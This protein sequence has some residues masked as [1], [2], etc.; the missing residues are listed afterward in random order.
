MQLTG[1]ERPGKCE[2][3]ILGSSEILHWGNTNC[4]CSSRD[5]ESELTAWQKLEEEFLKRTNNWE[6]NFSRGLPTIP[7]RTKTNKVDRIKLSKDWQG[8]HDVLPQMGILDTTS[9]HGGKPVRHLN[10]SL[11]WPILIKPLKARHEL[12]IRDRFSVPPE[13]FFQDLIN[14]IHNT[15][16]PDSP[17]RN[18]LY[19]WK[20]QIYPN[21]EQ[22]DY[23]MVSP[24]ILHYAHIAQKAT[25]IIMNYR[26]RMIL[27]TF[28]RLISTRKIGTR[29]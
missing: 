27:S 20:L 13:K 4:V 1:C 6:P 17:G 28:M 14:A 3:E 16:D 26:L 2:L 5:S 24:E 10:I 11:K 18:R 8:W 21:Q 12:M 9:K 15:P 22:K 25:N 19:Q 23:I 7:I 29:T